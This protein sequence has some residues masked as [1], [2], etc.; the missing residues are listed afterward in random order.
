MKSRQATNPGVGSV[1]TPKPVFAISRRLR[2]RLGDRKVGSRPNPARPVSHR[3]SSAPPGE[4]AGYRGGS[5]RVVLVFDRFFAA[6]EAIRV[7]CHD[8][9][10]GL[11]ETPGSSCGG[12]DHVGSNADTTPQGRRP[13]PRPEVGQA[14]VLETGKIIHVVL[15]HAGVGML[16][17]VVRG[18]AQRRCSCPGE[19]VRRSGGGRP[20]TR[21]ACH[22]CSV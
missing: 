8:P 17:S 21:L 7:R 3:S 14:P 1:P 6:P 19:S 12:N 16:E 18:C 2:V 15:V 5:R 9:Q 11:E 22:S 13:V 20:L 4:A 10:S